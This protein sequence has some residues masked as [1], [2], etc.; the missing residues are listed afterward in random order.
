MHGMLHISTKKGSTM[1]STAKKRV[2]TDA[3][4]GVDA[5]MTFLLALA[6]PVLQG[7]VLSTSV[8]NCPVNHTPQRL[9]PVLFKRAK[10][11][12]HQSPY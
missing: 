1:Q 8:V 11:L 6:S 4:L 5:A 10:F 3:S 7:V 9:M 12:C 2:L